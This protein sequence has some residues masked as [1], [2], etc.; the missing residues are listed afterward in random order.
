MSLS[1][2][3]WKFQDNILEAQKL[4][5]SELL[6][7]QNITASG[8]R[9]LA[10]HLLLNIDDL[11]GCWSIAT[12]WLR[13]QLGCSRV[14]TGFGS[15][16]ADE[17]FPSYAEAKSLDYSVPTLGGSAVDNRDTAMQAMWFADK[18]LI[19]ED[20]K[21]DRRIELGLRRRLSSAETQSKFAAVLRVDDQ[22]FGLICADWTK[23]RVPWQSHIYDH[24]CQTV[25][26]VLSPI[27]L[28]AYEI[29]KTRVSHLTEPKEASDRFTQIAQP[30]EPLRKLLTHA[31]ME[32]AALVAQG[33]S[34]KEIANR[35]DKSFSTIDH[36]LRSIRKKLNV[37]S[38]AQLI[39]LLAQHKL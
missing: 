37:S 10:A 25:S 7:K 23:E 28:V 6:D 18:P 24:F 3:D 2:N 26:E 11:D 33:I 36:Q 32:V 19:F 12:K 16:Q 15:P 8:S 9:D 30:P 14:D 39:R 20:I 21:Q 29:D 31:E 22:R 34:Y 4:L 5:R 17:Y 1:Q 38:T 13:D 27:I 35:R